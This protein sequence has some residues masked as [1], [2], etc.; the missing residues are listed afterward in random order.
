MCCFQ[1]IGIS[2]VIDFYG[3]ADRAVCID[4]VGIDAGQTDAPVGYGL[5]QLIIAVDGHRGRIVCPLV[6]DRV[7]QDAREQVLAVLSPGGAH[8]LVPA[9]LVLDGGGTGGGRTAGSG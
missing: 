8:Q 5:S 3:G 4:V 7:E 1:R 9:Q 6:R 2:E